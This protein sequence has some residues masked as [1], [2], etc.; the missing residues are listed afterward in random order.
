MTVDVIFL[1]GCGND[2]VGETKRIPQRRALQLA[3]TG[4]VRILE[5]ATMPDPETAER[6]RPVAVRGPKTERR[7]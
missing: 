7:G 5:T 2:G 4:Y 3:R 6:L 1:H